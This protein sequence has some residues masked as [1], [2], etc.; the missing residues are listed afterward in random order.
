MTEPTI[1]VTGATGKIGGAVAAELK[2]RGAHVRALVQRTMRA[3]GAFKRPAS[4]SRWPTLTT[5]SSSATRCAVCS[6]ASTCRL[7]TLT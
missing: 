5:P 3:A 6:V 1:L 4:R 2:A 7:T